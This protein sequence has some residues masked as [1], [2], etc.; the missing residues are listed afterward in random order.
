MSF[1]IVITAKCNEIW[2]G[3]QIDNSEQICSIHT[4]RNITHLAVITRKTNIKL[5]FERGGN[6]KR[7]EFQLR[8]TILTLS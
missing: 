8:K 6:W 4:L 1:N 2:R 7:A 5:Y 3:E